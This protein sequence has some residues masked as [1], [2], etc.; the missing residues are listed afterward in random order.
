MDNSK[1]RLTIPA[2]FVELPTW[3]DFA[4]HFGPVYS[5]TSSRL[6]AFHVAKHHTNPTGMC[7]GGSMA[8]FADMQLLAVAPRKLTQDDHWPTVSLSMDYVASAPLG[9]WVEALVTL[10]KR[11]R[12]MLFTQAVISV[13][14]DAV[15][16]SNAIYRIY[17]PRSGQ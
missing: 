1:A 3:P 5:N 2:G 6:I 11:T 17:Q 15:A 4:A 9:A 7:S 10:V 8:T 14:G 16:R 12:T 13:S